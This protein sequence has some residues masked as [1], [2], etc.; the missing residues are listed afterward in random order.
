MTPA[1]PK[2]HTVATFEEH[3]G[4]FRILCPACGW[5][6]EGTCS[7]ELYPPVLAQVLVAKADAP[8]HASALRVVREQLSF[9]AAQSLESL[10]SQLTSPDGLWLGNVPKY[11]INELR[12]KFSAAGVRLEECACPTVVDTKT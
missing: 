9:A 7:R 12:S 8:V 11:Q 1:C 2:C 4:V 10:R 3:G 5:H 6:E